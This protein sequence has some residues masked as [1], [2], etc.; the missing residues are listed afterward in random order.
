MAILDF[1]VLQWV[2][3]DTFG[4]SDI[5]DSVWQQNTVDISHNISPWNRDMLILGL[6][7]PSW[8]PSCFTTLDCT[9][10]CGTIEI[11]ILL[12]ITNILIPHTYLY[13][14]TAHGITFANRLDFKEDKVIAAH[15]V[16]SG[17][18]ESTSERLQVTASTCELP[19]IVSHAW[20]EMVDEAFLGVGVWSMVSPYADSSYTTVRLKINYPITTEYVR[21]CEVREGE[22]GWEKERAV[23]CIVCRHL[24]YK[25]QREECHLPIVRHSWIYKSTSRRDR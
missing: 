14:Q 2:G 20:V 13:H 6:W 9:C 17:R 4:L 1:Y 25:T 5:I 19:T 24:L 7:R 10:Q 3:I 16:K 21:D 11:R 18:M 12:E 8:S 23:V 15:S 22:K